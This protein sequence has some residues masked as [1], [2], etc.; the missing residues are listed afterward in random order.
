MKLSEFIEKEFQPSEKAKMKNFL[1]SRAS[2]D[3]ENVYKEPGTYEG[4]GPL[5]TSK[6]P[7]NK[8][9]S[10]RYNN[11]Y[12]WA[13]GNLDTGGIFENE[14]LD[15]IHQNLIGREFQTLQDLGKMVSRL[16]QS[17]FAHSDIVEFIKNYVA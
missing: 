5:D 12:P 9:T 16:Q 7:E 6:H 1:R 15:R 8:N 4:K 14:E 2:R 13:L 10:Q 3:Q 11:G 17:G